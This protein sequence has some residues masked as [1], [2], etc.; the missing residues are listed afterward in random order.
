M[1]RFLCFCVGLGL[2]YTLVLPPH[3]MAG[4]LIIQTSDGYN[5]LINKPLDGIFVDGAGNVAA[6]LRATKA[7]LQQ[8]A[9]FFN[10]EPLLSMEGFSGGTGDNSTGV[11]RSEERR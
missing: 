1:K 3:P 8:S 7:E 5:I 11:V 10:Y 9:S 2:V 6:E 4:N